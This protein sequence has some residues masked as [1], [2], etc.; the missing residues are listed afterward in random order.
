MV[1]QKTTLDK[2]EEEMGS[3]PPPRSLPPLVTKPG[4][5]PWAEQAFSAFQA[6]KAPNFK[7]PSSCRKE[8]LIDG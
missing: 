2:S 5:F 1:T 8:K 3:H 7:T 4:T 6:G